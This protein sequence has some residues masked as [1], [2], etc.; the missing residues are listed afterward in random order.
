MSG[1]W[2]LAGA[3]YL[4]NYLTGN[5][6]ILSF[7][8][9]RLFLFNNIERLFLFIIFSFNNSSLLW[10]GTRISCLKGGSKQL[11]PGFAKFQFVLAWSHYFMGENY[12]CR[13]IYMCPVPYGRHTVVGS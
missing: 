6:C 10:D 4:I 1:A 2:G 13:K 5:I 11:Q 9:K 3:P 12:E 8:K 7:K